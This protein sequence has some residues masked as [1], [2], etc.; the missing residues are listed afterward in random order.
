MKRSKKKPRPHSSKPRGRRS[1]LRRV[2]PGTTYLITK[3]IND[4]FFFL[5]PSDEVNELILYLLL[6]K[7]E[8]YGLLIHGFCFMSNHFH[9]LVTDLRGELPALMREFLSESSK[10]LKV[11]LGT[12]RQIWST[13]RYSSV[14]MLDLDAAEREAAY[15]AVN[16]T[17]AGFTE[18]ADWPG[19][20]SA[21][22]KFGDR[23]T[24]KRPDEYFSPRYRPDYVS[25][26]LAPLPQASF[27]KETENREDTNEEARDEQALNEESA[28]RIQ[29]HIDAALK[30]IHASLK[31]RKAKLAGR[32]RV[33]KTSRYKRGSHPIRGLN[34]RFATKN[35]E[36]L[37]S[38]IESFRKFEREHGSAV[39]RYAAGHSQAVFPRGTYGYRKLLGV[40]VGQ[41]GVAA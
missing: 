10:A 30:N 5:R 15:I 27:G 7:L 40:R 20:T 17:E 37:S 3:K 8:K 12:T 36:L 2:L 19:L 16:P 31:K 33:L 41:G 9:L 14:E 23:L 4:D 11:E 13:R 28:R 24:A 22:L 39:D 29:N 34:P 18:P 38:A 21:N 32:E 26:T 25:V 6:M 35:G 1:R